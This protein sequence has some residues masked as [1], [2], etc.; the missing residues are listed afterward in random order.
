MYFYTDIWS[1]GLRMVLRH[2]RQVR[3][4]VFCPWRSSA[5]VFVVV[6]L[7]VAG[8]GGV[9]GGAAVVVVV[10]VVVVVVVVGVLQ[11]QQCSNANAQVRRLSGT[12]CLECLVST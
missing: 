10:F 2:L 3:A 11:Q 4:I 1:L 9:G 5:F 12:R 7:V 8:V 6:I